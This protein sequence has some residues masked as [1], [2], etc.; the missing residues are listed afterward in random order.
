MCIRHTAMNL[1]A[2]LMSRLHRELVIVNRLGLHM[3]PIRLLVNT[4]SGFSSDIRIAK[5][6]LEVNG[7]SFLDVM[8]LAVPMNTTLRFSATGTDA[9]KALDA[10]QKLIEGKFNED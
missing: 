7:K 2:M 8:S 1:V 6:D 10:L 9:E 5:G 4:A 3:R